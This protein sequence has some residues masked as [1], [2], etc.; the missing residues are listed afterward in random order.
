MSARV[1]LVS[2]DGPSV[3]TAADVVELMYGDGAD[4]AQWIAV[5]VARLDPAF[6]DLR[7]RVAGE[8]VQT[9]AN[10]RVGLAIVGDISGYTATSAALAAFVTESNR[11]GQVKFVS[12]DDELRGRLRE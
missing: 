8:V 1:S 12:D 4:E 11:G 7:S 6:F 2:P 5:P 9:C 3:R 10:Y